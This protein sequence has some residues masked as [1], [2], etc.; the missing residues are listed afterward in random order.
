MSQVWDID[1]TS[2]A[3]TSPSSDA[4]RIFDALN[5]LR[6]LFSGASEPAVADQV[7]H[8]LWADT[9]A[10]LLKIRNAANT[11]WITVGALGSANL[12]LLS[13]AG[14][15][16]TGGLNSAKTTV[17]S[18]ATPD[19]FATSVGNLVDYTGTAIA[20]GF[21]TAPQGGPSRTLV[22]AS[23]CGF[24][25]GANLLID[26]VASGQTYTA[27]PGEHIQV[28]AVTSTQFRMTPLSSRLLEMLSKSAAYTTTSVDRGKL[29]NCTA[30]TF[31]LTLL[32]S[33]TAGA[34]FTQII[35]NSGNGTITIDPNGS[36]LID[37]QTTLKV[38]PGQVL[39]IL[40][41]GAGW[42]TISSGSLSHGFRTGHVLLTI[43][44]VPDP[45]WL[46]LNDTTIGSASSGATGRA[47]ADTEA[48]F[49][50][51]WNRVTDQWA[52]VSGGRGASAAADF[53]ANKRL[54]L[55]KA[56]GRVLGVAGNGTTV[57]SGV[58][59]GVNTTTDRFTVASNTATWLT[60]MPVVFTLS[61]GSI[62]GL[63]SGN[64]YYII[65]DS[66]ATVQLASSL[67]NAQNGTAIDLTAKSS[68][69]WTLTHSLDPRAIG[70][71]L[72]EDDHAMSSTELLGHQHSFTGPQNPNN[73]SAGGAQ[74]IIAGTQ[75]RTTVEAGGNA[76][77]NIMQPTLFL[78][79]MI[80]L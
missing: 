37:G 49:T 12:G 45:G 38:Y 29:I 22:C 16:L 47:N 33:A 55:T 35:R 79:A 54:A 61:S 9:T 43:D 42:I 3:T 46:L 19:I 20:T 27:A 65:R 63:A 66:S 30:N 1:L 41:M 21:T 67:D 69:V 48:L 14:G 58:D 70:E 78:Y 80:K 28:T 31:T 23:A 39:S 24:T 34:G 7:A 76:A 13:S 77:M 44:N 17:A 36:E 11:A 57:A 56:L 25:A 72:G 53:A 40:C 74:P 71:H 8:M 18:A 68:P 2:P 64:T 50:L 26:G 6:S 73:N 62:T 52:P 10:N 75:S 59:A 4:Q 5:T 15:N 51:L 60:G 32:P